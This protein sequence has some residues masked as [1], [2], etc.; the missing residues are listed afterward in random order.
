MLRV[1]NISRGNVIYDVFRVSLQ[2][3]KGEGGP[4]TDNVIICDD[5]LAVLGDNINSVPSEST[6][7]CFCDWS[8]SIKYPQ[9]PDQPCC[10]MYEHLPKAQQMASPMVK[11]CK[12]L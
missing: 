12:K 9:C 6:I 2:T 4:W 7:E 3:C 8:I 5:L 11:A 1:Q 10:Q